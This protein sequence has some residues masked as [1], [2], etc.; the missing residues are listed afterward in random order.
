MLY[1]PYQTTEG[2]TMKVNDI[3][4]KNNV[5]T[6]NQTRQKLKIF[7]SENPTAKR[8][9]FLGNSI[10]LHEKKPEIGWN[11]N[12]GMAASSEE[13]DYVHLVLA[14]LKERYGD[15]SYAI[16]N[17]AE[18][19]QKYWEDS[20]LEKF[21]PAKDFNA[22]TVVI[23]FGEN[24]N[25]KALDT[26]PLIDYLRTFIRH[27]AAEAKKIVVTDCFWEHERI[28]NALKTLAEENGYDFVHLFDLGYQEENMALGLFEHPGVAMHP[29]DLGMQRIAER[30]LE[31]L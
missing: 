16:V 18:W 1:Y 21:K 24:V 6:Q 25:L 11:N 22:D 5:D 15:I 7:E 20:V 4:V 14:R 29:G 30:I 10:T 13:K 31:K 2:N 17:V 19:E 8:V 23:R 26:Y 9:L 27:I 12:W 3:I 28:C